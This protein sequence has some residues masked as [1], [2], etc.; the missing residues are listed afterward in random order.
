MG[1]RIVVVASVVLVLG[2]G[3]TDTASSDL[4]VTVH[5]GISE[6]SK[7]MSVGD[8]P[9]AV[10]LADL[11]RV[12]F[13]SDAAYSSSCPPTAEAQVD[14]DHVTLLVG[15]AESTNC[16]SDASRVT[17][18]IDDVSDRPTRLVVREDGVEDL[19]LDL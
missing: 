14:G 6:A 16:T 15:P 19:T 13:V 10:W 8:L 1:L 12:V 4:S 9:D 17:F 18:I 11:G 7:V 5:S 2:C 3:S